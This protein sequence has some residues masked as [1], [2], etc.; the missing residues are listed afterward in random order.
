MALSRGFGN[1]AAGAE[2]DGKAGFTR[3]RRVEI[4]EP[5]GI[6]DRGLGSA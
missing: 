6:R 2:H 3:F 5:E 1:D 4:S